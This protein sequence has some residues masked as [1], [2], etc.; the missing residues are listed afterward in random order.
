MREHNLFSLK[1]IIPEREI[2]H[3]RPL[4]SP[5]FSQRAHAKFEA[6]TTCKLAVREIRNQYISAVAAEHTF[7]FISDPLQTQME[8]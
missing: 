4:Q 2:A 7:M 1:Y 8:S 5:T 3:A 6:L